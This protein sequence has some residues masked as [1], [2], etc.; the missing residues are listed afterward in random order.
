MLVQ[1]FKTVALMWY[2][3]L[4]QIVLSVDVNWSESVCC[5]IIREGILFQHKL[6]IMQLEMESVTNKSAIINRSP[7]ALLKRVKFE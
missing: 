5:I 3:H 7:V 1:K 2:L 6:S 4:S